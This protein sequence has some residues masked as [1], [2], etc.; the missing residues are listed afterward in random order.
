MN[1]LFV[2]SSRTWGGGEVWLKQIC[3]SLLS[4]GHRIVVV[5]Q[6]QSLLFNAL[7]G[8]DVETVGIKI[9]GDF[10]LF[11]IS[12]LYHLIRSKK[13]ELVCTNMEKEFRLCSLAALLA[14]I[15]V[16]ISREVDLPIKD[17][18]INKLFYRRLASGIMV[19]SYATY[20]SLL[21][22][23]PWLR[24]Q[25]IEIVWKGIDTE[26]YQPD[27]GVNLRK[28][29]HLTKDDCIA[30]FVGRLDEQKGIPTLLRSIKIAVEKESRLKFV[31][32]GDGNLHTMIDNFVSDNNLK[33]H[34]FLLGFR[35]D[36]PAFLHGIDFL[37]MPSYW[38]GF[39]YTA[40]EAMA[41]GK[42]VIGTFTSSLPE[43]IEH[44]RTG[45]LVPPRAMEE[46]AEAIVRLGQNGALRQNMGKA[47]LERARKLFQLS[48]M[49]SKTELFFNDVCASY[50]SPDKQSKYAGVTNPAELSATMLNK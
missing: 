38:E 22:S 6:Q 43:I 23:A 31:F 20:N 27:I 2:S 47:G 48:G 41:A 13:I 46:L 5:C 35:S 18:F 8:L 39:G 42:P 19:N 44:E 24:D 33:A 29:L 26:L 45:I 10:D 49:V 9:S 3:E 37:V 14:K 36:I 7:I 25:K 16:T 34:I 11:T 21:V 17:T 15:P 50:Y 4:R 12:K 32:A 1:I 40:V 28:E 30:G